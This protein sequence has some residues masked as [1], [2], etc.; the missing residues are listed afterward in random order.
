MSIQVGNREKQFE[1]QGSKFKVEKP[2]AKNPMFKV[3]DPR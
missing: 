3:Q 1:V 2:K